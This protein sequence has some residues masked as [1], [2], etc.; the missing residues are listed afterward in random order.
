[1]GL[2]GSG[3]AQEKFGGLLSSLGS[4]AVS[5]RNLGESWGEFW[6]DVGGPRGLEC[7][8]LTIEGSGGL[9][10]NLGGGPG[11]LFGVS[12]GILGGSRGSQG[13]PGVPQVP[14]Q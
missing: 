12:P 4:P 3:G 11:H 6:G 10:R 7:G 5:G 1:M 8:C 2:W 9:G 13:A 14:S